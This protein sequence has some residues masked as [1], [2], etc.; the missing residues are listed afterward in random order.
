[1]D[2]TVYD[3]TA[4]AA[5][6]LAQSLLSQYIYTQ[7]V[8]KGLLTEISCS[9]ASTL[10]QDTVKLNKHSIHRCLRFYCFSCDFPVAV[11]ISKAKQVWSLTDIKCAQISHHSYQW[12]HSIKRGEEAS[13]CLFISR[14]CHWGRFHSVLMWLYS[15]ACVAFAKYQPFF[16]FF[17]AWLREEPLP[18]S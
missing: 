4:V 7:R 13:F 14:S 9:S 6:S 12:Q 8:I 3:P 2:F 16:F 1:M 10:K 17:A 11:G 18:S 15:K 5:H